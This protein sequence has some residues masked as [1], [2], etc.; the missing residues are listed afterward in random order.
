MP[1][2]VFQKLAEQLGDPKGQLLFITNTARCG[3]TLL[4]Q[5]FEESE[6]SIAL[7]EPD[8]MNAISQFEHT[9]RLHLTF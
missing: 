7:S 4:T 1:I 8:A 6:H 3:S 9:V 2:G 5:V